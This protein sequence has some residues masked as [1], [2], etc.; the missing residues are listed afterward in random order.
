MLPLIVFQC[1]PCIV[2]MCCLYCFMVLPVLFQCAAYIVSVCC[3]CC[4]S[5]LPVLFQIVACIVSGTRCETSVNLCTSQP[6][7]N[8]GVCVSS[9]GSFRCQCP[10]THAGMYCE[11]RQLCLQSETSASCTLRLMYP[12]PHVPSASCTLRLMYPPPHVPFL[13]LV[14]MQ[15]Y[16]LQQETERFPAL[17]LALDPKFRMNG[18][19]EVTLSGTMQ[20]SL[21]SQTI[22]KP[23]SSHSIPCSSAVEILSDTCAFFVIMTCSF[24]SS[25]I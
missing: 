2:S 12:P 20:P 3:Q 24:S 17:S 18:L 6:C 1:V 15:H 9:P 7:L 10:V 11:R 22:S 21:L 13:L 5:V 8:G 25:P 14:L 19:T 23:T 16:S 4:F